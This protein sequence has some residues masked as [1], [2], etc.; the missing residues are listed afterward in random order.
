MVAVKKITQD[1]FEIIGNKSVP[2]GFK[3]ELI[4][5]MH[6]ASLVQCKDSV[7]FHFFPAYMNSGM[8]NLAPNLY[9][10]LKGKTCFHFKK[11]EQIHEA[12]L[13]I[14]LNEGIK[15]WAKSGYLLL[16]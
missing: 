9:K 3:K 15:L 2:Y 7:A 4:P 8:I 10:C 11:I 6:F 16:P 5:G 13:R 14:L 1:S 12:E